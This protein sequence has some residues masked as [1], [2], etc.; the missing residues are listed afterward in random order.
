M[1][2]ILKSARAKLSVAF[3]PNVVYVAD[4]VSQAGSQMVRLQIVALDDFFE[5]QRI[6]S[7]TS[8]IN[9]PY[10]KVA[11]FKSLYLAKQCVGE[12]GLAL[13]QS[14]FD[15]YEDNDYPLYD[16]TVDFV[17]VGQCE[18]V[19]CFEFHSK[20]HDHNDLVAQ[21]LSGGFHG[22]VTINQYG[23]VHLAALGCHNRT[24]LVNCSEELQVKRLMA[25]TGFR[26]AILE[27][28]IE[29]REVKVLDAAYFA[30][31]WLSDLSFPKRI[32]YV[33]GKLKEAGI[34]SEMFIKPRILAPV[35][36]LKVNSEG[37]VKG[38][39]VRKASS[40]PCVGRSVETNAT[41]T[42]WVV[43]AGQGAPVK[44]VTAIRDKTN[45]LCGDTL[46]FLYDL[47]LPNYVCQAY[48][49]VIFLAKCDSQF[50]LPIVINYSC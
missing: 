7:A 16:C 3:V 37:F 32:S 27:V 36:L 12:D 44:L 33:L 11:P 1:G 18:P 43:M 29:N 15:F 35:E 8:S 50:R 45:V 20:H 14:G 49:D 24:R 10:K 22:I 5:V 31:R 13:E 47:E 39:M 34:S 41:A 9:D 28:V 4:Y 23:H 40:K 38:Y 2:C 48:R 19:N 21:P 30:D 42:Q 46:Q 17:H 25:V 6:D 26:G